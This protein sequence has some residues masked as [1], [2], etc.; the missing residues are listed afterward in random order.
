MFVSTISPAIAIVSTKKCRHPG[1]SPPL[2]VRARVET[3]SHVL[4]KAYRTYLLE[5]KARSAVSIVDKTGGGAAV[6]EQ[7]FGGG[8]LAEDGRPVVHVKDRNSRKNT[9]LS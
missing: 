2:Q 3:D 1:F 4:V 6:Q 9:Y 7:F 5:E 8:K